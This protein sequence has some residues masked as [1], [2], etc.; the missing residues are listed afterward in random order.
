M[1]SFIGHLHPL[2]V[3][4]PIGFLLLGVIFWG[5]QRG[6]VASFTDEVYQWILLLSGLVGS[7]TVLSGFVQAS[8]EGFSSSSVLNHKVAGD[9][10]TD[11][12]F[13]A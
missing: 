12:C 5:M 8:E 1:T 7:V 4:L 9:Q 13:L 11:Y 10:L 2:L 6:K 3:H